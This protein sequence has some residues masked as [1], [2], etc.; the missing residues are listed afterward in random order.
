[1]IDEKSKFRF[2]LKPSLSSPLSFWMVALL[3]LLSL[4]SPSSGQVVIGERSNADKA[5]ILQLNSN[6]K[7]ILIPKLTNAQWESIPVDK[8]S[9]GLWIMVTEDRNAD[10]VRGLYVYV[11][12]N[13]DNAGQWIPIVSKK[14]IDVVLRQGRDAE[15]T[16]SLW[17][18]DTIQGK[19]VELDSLLLGN[20]YYVDSISNDTLLRKGGIGDST[21]LVTVYALKIYYDNKIQPGSPNR[22]VG[23]VKNKDGRVYADTIAPWLLF[24]KE[25]GSLGVGVP[26][27]VPPTDNLQVNGKIRGD[28]LFLQNHR[29]D[30][31]SNSGSLVKEDSMALTTEYAAKKRVDNFLQRSRAK[32][33]EILF[34]KRDSFY[35]DINFKWYQQTPGLAIGGTSPVYLMQV[36]GGVLR[37]D[38]LMLHQKVNKI[39][40]TTN[41]WSPKPD[42]GMLMTEY[43]INSY[44]Q[45]L[46]D[47][48]PDKSVLF[49]VQDTLVGTKSFTWDYNQ[50]R[51]GIGTST[52]TN[53]L[54]I[55][56][57]MRTDSLRLLGGGGHM[58]DT[59]PNEYKLINPLQR[60]LLTEYAAKK[61]I[62]YNKKRKADN[63]HI[64][65]LKRTGTKD[66]LYGSDNLVWR[67][68][69]SRMG[70][71]SKSPLTLLH[72]KGG[73]LKADTLVLANKLMEVDSISNDT[74]FRA[75][76]TMSLFTVYALKKYVG[77]KTRT[78]SNNKEILFIGTVP[79]SLF[80]SK[81]LTFDYEKSAL[82]AG[83]APVGTSR[84]RVSGGILRADTFKLKNN[85]LVD[86]ISTDTLLGG[87]TPDSMSLTSEYSV[88]KYFRGRMQNEDKQVIFSKGDTILYGDKKLVWD[89]STSRLGVGIS[90]P[91]TL[92]H[93]GNGVVSLDSFRLSSPYV[94]DSI[95]N[96]TLLG[97]SSPD[98]AKLI[99]EYAVPIYVK[100]RLGSSYGD[101]GILYVRKDS[102]SVGSALTWD[103]DKVRMGLGTSSPESR[104]HVLG[105]V[106]R[107]DSFHLQGGMTVDSMSD[108]RIGGGNYPDSM[109]LLTEEA[110]RHFLDS[111]YRGRMLFPD[112]VNWAGKSRVYSNSAVGSGS[113][114]LA[115][116]IGLSTSTRTWLVYDFG[117]LVVVDSIRIQG[118][119]WTFQ[120]AGLAVLHSSFQFEG[121]DN[122]VRW[123]TLAD[124]PRQLLSRDTLWASGFSN[125]YPYRYYRI[126]HNPGIS[127]SPLE[128]VLSKGDEVRWS[129]HG[130]HQVIHNR[131][132]NYNG[133]DSLYW[134]WKN[135]RLGIGTTTPQYRIDVRGGISGLDTLRFGNSGMLADSIV[136]NLHRVR[137]DSHAVLTEVGAADYITRR[138]T[139][140]S[141]DDGVL[142]NRGDTLQGEELFVFN[143]Q[144]TRLGVGTSSPESRFSVV[145][146][147]L[148]A[149]TLMLSGNL[150]ADSIR[151]AMGGFR[152]GDSN[153]LV[154][155][156]AV[157]EY[158]SSLLR[159]RVR[160]EHS[161]TYI[162]NDS[163][164]SDTRFTYNSSTGR[165]G[166]KRSSPSYRMDVGGLTGVDTFRLGGRYS[167]SISNDIQMLRSDSQSLVTEYSYSHYVRGRHSLEDGE[168]SFM[169][170]DTI[171]GSSFFHYDYVNSRLGV[172]RSTPRHRLDVDGETR[173]DSFALLGGHWVDSISVDAS[174][175]ENSSRYLVTEGAARDY[176]WHR[177]LPTFPN[178]ILFNRRDSVLSNSLLHWDG[179]K[180]S[181]GGVQAEGSRFYARNGV[182]SLDSF[183]L[184]SPYV[185]DSI[186]ND[187]LL[188][189][190]S[191]DSTKLITEYVVPIYVKNRL[192]SSYGDKGILYV[193]KDSLSVGSALT[194]DYDKVRMG[195]GTSSP[196]SRFHVLG[197]VSRSDSFHLQGGM[198]VDS[199][200][201][202]RIGG[203][204]Y[205]D[206]MNLLTEEASRH[207]LDSS[208]RGRMLFPDTVNW[209]GK[210]RVYSNSAVGSGSTG[211]AAGIGLS[212]STRTWLVY[213]FGRLVVV[214]SIRIQG[215]A[216]TFQ[217]AG[218]AV[219]H[220][221]FQF[222]GSDNGVR[223]KTLADFPRQLLSRDTLWASGFSNSYPYRY[224]R[225]VH[226]PGISASPLELV[227]SKGDEVRWSRHGPHQVIHNR[228]GNY[229]GNDSLYWDWKN[230]RL[231]IGTT[232]PQYRIDVRGGISGLD[233]LRFGNS[234][235]L[236][237]SIVVN[238]HRVRIDSHAV[239]TEVGAAD[240]ITRRF[241]KYSPD[242]GVL[243]NRGDT[244]Q[245]EEL[246]VFNSQHT[247]LGV[248]T[249]SPE[250]RFSVVGGVLHAD[251][252]MLSGNL[253]ADS[254]RNAM[255]GFRGGDSNSLVTE[256][257]VNEYVSSLLR[258]RVREE[259]SIT[260]IR[261]DSVYSDTRFTYN[262]STGRMGVKRSSPSYRMDV[263]GLTGVDTFRL[264][265]RYSDSISNDIQMLRSDSQSLVTEY[266]Y[267]HYVRGRHSLEDGEVSFMELDTIEGSSFFHYDYVN[268]R[269]GVGRS[270]PRHRLDVDG[271]TRADSFALLGGHW[272][273]S[274][275]VDASRKENSSRYLVT[276]GA[277]RDYV[278]HR[279]LPTFPNQ[280]L[281]NRRDSVLSN[282]LLHWD[283]GK[284]SLGGV[285]AEGSRF[286]ARNGVVSLDSFRLSSPY[287]VDSISN[288]TLLGGSSPDRAKLITEYVV[289]IYVKNRLGSSYGDKGILYVRKDSLSVGS[290][291]TWDYDKVRMGLGTSSP[292][293]RFHVLGGVS[294]SDSFH[295]QGG[296]IVDSMSD[297]R[298]GGGNYP[299]S[300]NLL[301]EEASRHFLDSSYRGRM[302]FPDTVNWAGKSRVY[303]NS[304]VGSGST[305]LAAGIGLS[306]STRTWLVYD[307]G[308]LVV[309]DSIRI[310]GT[311]WT[312][313]GA[314][315][316]VLHSSF[317]FEGSDN[318][319]R[320]KTLA[321][322][323]RQLLSRDTLWASGFSNSYPYRYYRIVHN[324]G[325]SASPL[326]LVLSKGD[327][328]R[329]SRHGPHQVIHNRAGNYNGNDS[330]YWDWKNKRLGIGTTTPQYRIDVRGG[331]SGLD[332]LRFG[333]SGMLADSIVV[334]LH[335]VR[336]DSHAV[337]TEVGAADYITRRFT[338]Y[339]PD[340]GVLFNRG[341][342]LQGEELF[343]FN[344]QHTRLGVGTSSPESRFSVVGGVLHADTLMLS[345]NLYADSI[346][347]AMGGFRGGDSN[348]LVTEYAVNE[349][350]SSLLRERVR[351]E[352]SITYIRND[353]VYSDTRFIYNSSTGRM[354]VKRSSP[355][356][357]MDVGGLTGV[358]TF[359]LGGRYSDSISNDI[360]MLRSDSQSLVTEYSYSHYVRGRHSLE[361]GEVSFME[362][363][364]IEGSSFFHYDYVNSRLGVGRS[365]PRHRLD[366]DGET[367][368]DSFAL[369]GGHWVDSISVDASRK[370]N[371]SRYLV[372]EGAARDYVW[373]RYLPT[374]PNQILFNRR[375]SVL[376]NSLLHWDGG[377][378]SLGGVQAEGSRFYARNGVVS[379]DSFRLS[380]PYVV[381]SISNDTLLGGSSPDSTKLITEYVVPLYVKNRLGSSYG[382]KGI[383]YVRK[384]SLSVGSALTWDY[385]K[386]RMGLG[387]SS[388]E[389]RFHVL[390]GV[391]RSDSFHL[392]GGMIVDSMSDNRI[393]G[394]NYPDS[395]N[396]LTEEASRHFLD[397][398]YRGRMLFPD[399][400]NWAGK[401]RVYSNSAVGSGSTGLAA[402]I[403]LSTSTRT[404]LVYD[405]GRLVVVDSIRIQGTAWSFPGAGLT[406]LHSSF[407]FEGSD[408][409]LRW[410]T[411]ADF[412]KQLLS[413]DTLWASGFSN[414]YP[415]RYY[416]IVHNPG[417]SA[418]PLE[419]VLSKGDEVRWSRHGPHQV[420]HNRAGNYN[421]NDSLYWDWK[422]KRLGIGTTTPQYRIDVRGGISGLDT[423]RFGNS[424]ML[425]DSIVVNLHRVRIDSHAVLTEVGAADYITRRFTKY[426]PDDGV[427]FNR[428]D[429]LQ[430]EELFV[431][432][433]QH[434][435]LGV[436]T[437]SPESRFSVVGGVLHADTLMLSGN[438][439]ADSI[440]NAMGGFRGGDSNSLVTEYAVNE[441]VSSL[442]RERVREEHSITYIRNDSVYSDTRFIYNSSTGR[443]GVKRSSPSYRMDVGGLTGVDTFRLGGRYSDSISN[444]IQ[445]LRSDSQSLVTEYSY[446]H[447]VR[448]RHSLEDGEVS[449]MELD[450]IEGSSFF[451]Y[452][453]VNSRLGVGRSA[454]RHRLDVDGETRADSF[455][456][457]GGHWVD[458][459]SVDASRKENSSRYL[460]TEGAARDYVWHRY[461]PTFPNQI[462]FN[463]RDSVL[464][465]ALLHW[466]GGKLSLGGVQAEG[467]RFYARNGVVSLD[468][469]RL[470]SP[471]V[472]DS[473][474]ND[475]LL[476]GSSPDS[477]K[478][479][480]EYVVPLYV[481][482][483][484]GSSYGDK[485]ILY[486]RKDSLS[487]GSALTWD[488]D[489]VRMGLGTSSPESRFHVLGGVSRSDSFHLQGGMTVDSMSDN[490]I[491]GGN[492]PDRMN[493]LTEEASR[494][495]LD[496]SYRGRML[497]PDTINWAGKSRVYSNSDVGSGST[498]LAAG[499]G[500]STSTRTW[501]VYDFGR[502]VVVDSIR[503]QGTAWSFPG[504]GSVALHS[505]FQFEGSDNGLRWK[506]LADFP[507]QLLSRDT[508]WASGFS[509]S[510]PYRYYRIVHDPGVSA[511]PL[512]LVLSKG[513]EVRWSRHGPHQV[514]H[515]RAG[516]YNGNDSLYWD[517]KNKRLGIGTTTPQYRIDVRGGTSGLDTLRLKNGVFADSIVNQ[518]QGAD[519][520]N[521][522]VTQFAIQ[523]YLN[524]IFPKE[525][526]ITFL[527]NNKITNDSSLVFDPTNGRI[528]VGI[529]SPQV[530]LHL[531]EGSAPGT[532]AVTLS[533]SALSIESTS[534]VYVEMKSDYTNESGIRFSDDSDTRMSLLRDANR[535]RMI[536]IRE[537]STNEFLGMD[538]GRLRIGPNWATS[539]L[540]RH[541][542]E[543]DRI[544]SVTPTPAVQAIDFTT[545]P[546]AL[547]LNIS[548]FFAGW[549][550]AAGYASVSDSRVKHFVSPS[551]RMEDFATLRNIKI[552]DYRYIDTLTN[553]G[554]TF[555]KVVAQ[556]LKAVYPR[557]VDTTTRNFI[558]SVYALSQRVEKGAGGK[559]IIALD[560]PHGLRSGDRVRLFSVGGAVTI[561]EVQVQSIQG[562]E[563]FTVEFSK[564]LGQQLFVYGKEVSDFHTVDYNSLTT[565][566]IS[567]MQQ[568]AEIIEETKRKKEK[569]SREI[570][571]I[572]AQLDK[573]GY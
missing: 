379:L 530:P 208:Y 257:A 163:V 262:S 206:R 561:H 332:T 338:K 278:W 559:Y 88:S 103:Y 369:L 215:T 336:I 525:K 71:G 227:L 243:F 284:L 337:L 153:S 558:P 451:H 510:Y 382:D 389:S 146:G 137:I 494:H 195:L 15:D 497:F 233:T 308:R 363:D 493:L 570:E 174:R 430:G 38:T 253:Y 483:R 513:D 273:D 314:G 335:R 321:D 317:Q 391:S 439:Y 320:W 371:S 349:Y 316:A 512:E 102:L 5:A 152:G 86:S 263:G 181:L 172:G 249:S 4:P 41:F 75:G 540:T 277:A 523:S 231:G 160:E 518:I 538:S 475:T 296:M 162:R 17:R 135:K 183:R 440:R 96:D 209:A 402:G 329:W 348:S 326:E 139:K 119:A 422:N 37:A 491:G 327:E 469:F 474:S 245:G 454:P 456:L 520:S 90:T 500:L 378:L 121:S 448:G 279:Y 356:Y 345:G 6:S 490:R 126:V 33:E 419:L 182:V 67:Y 204:N 373:H 74:L 354:G 435:R 275:S 360:Q 120:G 479:I 463:R 554:K 410:K 24:D 555:K 191:P 528:G 432:N 159:E 533:K 36:K 89:Q 480:T 266:S 406:A 481:K 455:A 546:A 544:V 445:M 147:V 324:P 211:L 343:V 118:T 573:A 496:S 138:F 482:N 154:T 241:T 8:S 251:T 541:P 562:E 158:V 464:S 293:S 124:F 359:R 247:R 220:S 344:S 364:T 478:L 77:V 386:V 94:V 252:L 287:V 323:P 246:F 178:Q 19:G 498:G 531:R 413:R 416:R 536:F 14:G 268:S 310:Q 388:P 128:L 244:L 57:G 551:H 426:S 238:L 58:V 28:T 175:K 567:A 458:S 299:D 205:P 260:Y 415:Y 351:E 97:G 61:H 131:A 346:R 487:V 330:L 527:Q 114:G 325:I 511:S 352:H 566:S 30:S 280:I 436:G 524:S 267:S 545:T 130:P 295:L 438:L 547:P 48:R 239:L 156:Y 99:T 3:C 216:W 110:S 441:Y 62:S 339:S 380:S 408:N 291:L 466:D 276:E 461:L 221:S 78:F 197:G 180:L 45:F 392:Q 444:D 87:W 420:I 12:R 116:G 223:W 179:G 446:S 305:G 226:N 188:G 414:S 394:G 505:D 552:R 285:Q 306:T 393:G 569:L 367:R 42:S 122:G 117:R 515:N 93:V 140:Y 289:P 164:Y 212:T 107:S 258:E 198:I 155:E 125:S 501:L 292:E 214:D 503:I 47:K 105:G 34:A 470:S 460:V 542:L 165:M 108:N 377:K 21:K 397:S 303:S 471:Y 532:P 507:N 396:L 328:V 1:M 64:H 23:Y 82:S 255:G 495:F 365:T 109:N 453:Y 434:T 437:S 424:G 84:F 92:V 385:D 571:E 417:I 366:V 361:D 55:I 264:G 240:Y 142:F 331:I 224:Y 357:R 409:G 29:V 368:A 534:D 43:P 403:G 70:V 49:S 228:A 521:S 79:D 405:F 504:A 44:V 488:Y 132:G 499:I 418:S 269:L 52:P 485:G 315:L 398:S 302:L 452:D 484:L 123:K 157:N 412:P 565:L 390:G 225:I 85:R 476:G 237:D 472:V 459:I 375:D 65:F 170:L 274:I 265:G 72:V 259:H 143:S 358:D 16:L 18:L 230:K 526:G 286:Y 433:S 161:I 271:E 11:W 149:D 104:F 341:D 404:W 428:G 568:L 465:N 309:V 381:D 91:T 254:I 457:L 550:V 301:T 196:E 342:T 514:I 187:T 141:P 517:W 425:A 486:V 106:S 229:N 350:V 2:R 399:T 423:L 450:T 9:S 199:M 553:G 40:G 248:G 395:M 192:G 427:L 557:A 443:M 171:E 186:S 166:V 111:S 429:T 300:M 355:S 572:E 516:N 202:N 101:K 189:G 376:S 502:L 218:L 136:V 411:L 311:A 519:G 535:R 322:F 73:R 168:V 27:N 347:N 250:S 219:L 95:S 222:E 288:D 83:S 304:A 68:D 177:Y 468:S 32:S 313:Q 129:R 112:T 235:M 449:F 80:G 522:L 59:I 272:V 242:D 548:A 508:L 7:G 509:N 20:T 10:T 60:A 539:Q 298:I 318:G 560:K 370:E 372:T 31:I 537:S 150:Y 184:S 431:F 144:H 307:F 270:T 176:V 193:R 69:L 53:L 467:S 127:A 489:K 151:N 312:F 334:N 173:A 290:A 374:F 133:N 384:D 383:L 421:G 76:D 115:A 145:G 26:A 543:V 190:S 56:G 563:T 194:W 282:S 340:D 492:Y 362:L 35:G 217:G 236:A 81:Y 210:S 234:G 387:T 319:V 134:D 13:R 232:T 473:I 213:D 442:L 529:F 401:S 556:E 50:N 407:Q 261:N 113:T 200:S 22:S 297:N 66:S 148:H 167:D 506:T 549:S 169:E 400:V 25:S 281:F 46:E 462:L 294:R 39:S 98:R 185:V 203:G 54:H 201:D 283:G 333:N 477:T 207:F 100:N 447:Y 564:E 63:F 256:Y 51:L 353:S